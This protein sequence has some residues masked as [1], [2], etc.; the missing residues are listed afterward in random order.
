MRDWIGG[1]CLGI[2]YKI[3]ELAYIS[4][5]FVRVWGVEEDCI[6]G[7]GPDCDCACD[8]VVGGR[9]G[10]LCLGYGARGGD[11]ED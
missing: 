9:G 8:G 7:W 1:G 10:G 6:A 2:G 3:E 4:V 11:H 5:L